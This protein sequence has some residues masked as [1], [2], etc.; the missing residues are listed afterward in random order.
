MNI[1]HQAD[2][3]LSSL[4]A[5]EK[6]EEKLNA[7]KAN[8]RQDLLALIKSSGETSYKGAFARVNVS[9]KTT[10]DYGEKVIELEAQVKAAK[11]VAKKTGKVTVVSKTEFVRITWTE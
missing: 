7:Q 9:S 10:Y 3:I 6:E 2:V 5:I 4:S 8:L 1:S 11:E